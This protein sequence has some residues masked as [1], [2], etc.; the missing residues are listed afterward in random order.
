MNVEIAV[1]VPVGK[2]FV[3]DG[4]QTDWRHG[5][6]YRFIEE[7][8]PEIYRVFHTSQPI[9]DELLSDYDV[10]ISAWPQ[11]SYSAD[12]IS[13]IQ[14]FVDSGGG[15]LVIGESEGGIYND[16]TDYAG[17]SWGSPYMVLFTGETGEINSHEITENVDSIYF[18]SHQL[19][20]TV[21]GP[22]E[23]I[24][25]TYDGMTYS[26]VVVA[27]SEYGVGK[28][29]AIAD[30]ECLNSEYIYEVD[31]IIF[32]QN[33]I[34]WLT[35][36]RP[37]SIIDS[38]LNGGIYN[39]GESIFFDGS[40]SY[41]PDGDTLNYLW[42]SDIDGEIGSTVSFSTVLTLGKHTI[43]LKVTDSA[44]KT[45]V[46]QVT[47]NLQSPPEV[48]IL[49]PDDGTL[50]NDI[51]TISGTA[52]DSDGALKQV[53]VKIDEDIWQDA[54]DSSSSGDWSTWT[55]F[56]DSRL[57]SDGEHTI[58]VRSQDNDLLYSVVTT[59]TVTIDNTA[60]EIITGPLV[61]SKTHLKATIEW[62]T[63]E[64]CDSTIEYW[65][66]GSSDVHSE[67]ESSYVSFHSIDLTDLQ[68]STT[69][70]FRVESKDEIGNTVKSQEGSFTTDDP[71][72]FTPPTAKIKSPDDGDIV[73]GTVPI[74][75]DASDNVEIDRVEFYIDDILKYTDEKPGYS[76]LWDTESGHYPDD[77]YII[78]VIA[79]DPSNNIGIDE[80]LVT[81]NNEIMVPTIVD[82]TVTPDSLTAGEF[83]DVLFKIEL[84][85]PE[86][87]I[88][89]VEIDLS[90]LGDSSDQ[91]MYDDGTHGDESAGDD[92]YSYETPISPDVGLGEI[93]L[94]IMVYYGEGESIETYVELF[95]SEPSDGGDGGSDESDGSD[96]NDGSDGSDGSSDPNEEN[97]QIPWI[98][99]LFIP[100]IGTVIFSFVYTASKRNRSKNIKQAQVVPQYQTIYYQ[101]PSNYDQIQQ[102]KR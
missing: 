99:I 48:A 17:I 39:P 83:T 60:P 5:I 50:K 12:E 89:S 77:D 21:S 75:V 26:R 68:P 100:I 61:T 54:S 86:N 98:F 20:L 67:S 58:S 46:F 28:V 1:T 64:D 47:I 97:E 52:L 18:D 37:I 19:P 11:Q 91:N 85:D 41:D 44:G 79:R 30:E 62:E 59:I 43:T 82:A 35:N 70:Y 73:S 36:E 66:M 72:D 101:Y 29:V 49:S 90:P 3:D 42:T 14:S 63:N 6:F 56:W 81:L 15:L 102:Y 38:P 10:F 53:E 88:G 31:N 51:V 32:G 33:I 96:G 16:L 4:H 57:S 8:A 71:P 80:I 7:I 27:A 93:S 92:I 65:E 76:W 69:Y 87:A 13:A 74:N 84:S 55:Y 2:I 94:Q 22:A 24:V 78:K 45:G 34:R 9:T 25:Y 23:E 40:S 95:I